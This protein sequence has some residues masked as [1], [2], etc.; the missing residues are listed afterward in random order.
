MDAATIQQKVWAGYGAAAGRVG[1]VF[2]QYR[3]SGPQTPLGTANQIGSLNAAFTVAPSGFDFERAPAH[4]NAIFNGLFD[5]AGVA[6]GDYLVGPGGVTYFVAGLAP[7]TPPLCVLCNRVLTVH[8]PGPSGTFG[9]QAAY[10]GTAPANETATMTAWPANLLFDARGRATEVGLP[11]DLPSPFYS[12]LMPALADVD[13][14]TGM[15]LTDDQARRYVVS[16]S[17]RSAFG[18]RLFAQQAVT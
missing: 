5:A 6:V 9:V 7:L 1:A 14:R 17:E 12:I 18:W 13:V 10:Q 2:G 4:R 15:I 3:P 11:L 16:A 8:T